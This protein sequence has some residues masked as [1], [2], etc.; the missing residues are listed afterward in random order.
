MIVLHTH[1]A[2]VIYRMGA[3]FC[4]ESM[5]LDI[6]KRHQSTPY[7]YAKKELEQRLLNRPG[8][9]ELDMIRELLKVEKNGA[10][11]RVTRRA[12]Q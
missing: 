7:Q 4:C 2:I 12:L 8:R 10:I 1:I 11:T 9:L 5:Q 3:Q 6:P